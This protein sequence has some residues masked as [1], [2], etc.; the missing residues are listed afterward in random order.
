MHE[1]FKLTLA[2]SALIG[3]SIAAF[4]IIAGPPSANAADLARPLPACNLKLLDEER[5][6][7][8]HRYNGQVIYVDFW[9]SWCTSCAQSFP[10]LNA[11]H[12]QF[13]GKGLFIVGINVDE[14]LVDARAFLRTTPA[15]FAIAADPNGVCP[16]LFEVPAMPASYLIDRTGKIRYVHL[17][18]REK[19]QTV[20]VKHVESL[21]A[22]DAK[23]SG[24]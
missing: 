8:L 15:A 17:G 2:R 14:N 5:S 24:P 9:A 23:R 4:S 16:S 3:M 19:D 10:F 20:I 1:R 18:Y 11:L 22:E 13:A 12:R 21:L 6:L 7:D